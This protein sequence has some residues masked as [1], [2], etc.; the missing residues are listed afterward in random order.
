[1]KF[2]QYL[3]IYLLFEMLKTNFN[4]LDDGEVSRHKM[5]IYLIYLDILWFDLFVFPINGGAN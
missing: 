5:S 1:M 3:F 2:W 4:L